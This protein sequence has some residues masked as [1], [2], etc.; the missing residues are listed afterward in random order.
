MPDPLK[1]VSINLCYRVA[2]LSFITSYDQYHHRKV[3][4]ALASHFHLL[5]DCDQR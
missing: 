5:L 3:R 1:K 2:M 4:G